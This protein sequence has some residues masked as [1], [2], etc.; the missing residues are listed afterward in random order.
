[1]L[2]CFLSIY[3]LIPGHLPAFKSRICAT[4]HKE[5]DTKCHRYFKHRAYEPCPPL[6]R[7]EGVYFIQKGIKVQL[8]LIRNILRHYLSQAR[9]LLLINDIT[10]FYLLMQLR[11]PPIN[12][13]TPPGQYAI[14]NVRDYLG[15]GLSQWKA[16]LRWNAAF[17]WLNPY[18]DW[19]MCAYQY[20]LSKTFI[21]AYPTIITSICYH[22]LPVAITT[23]LSLPWIYLLVTKQ[24]SQVLP[25]VWAIKIHNTNYDDAWQN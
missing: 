8:W 3:L 16:T 10:S 24:I 5:H 21:V 19:S 6:V 11:Y 18:P 25:L 12:S 13:V 15:S 23:C 9:S 2:S 14:Y 7:S 4:K 1:M 17:H 20:G 22:M